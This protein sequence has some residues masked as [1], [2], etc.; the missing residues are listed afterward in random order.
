MSLCPRRDCHWTRNINYDIYINPKT[1]IVYIR[2]HYLFNLWNWGT[3][4]WSE[5]WKEKGCS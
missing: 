3:L 1:G 5:V 4:N 2:I